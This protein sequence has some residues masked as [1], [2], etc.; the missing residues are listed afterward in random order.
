[1]RRDNPG[2][3]FLFVIDGAGDLPTVL[4]PAEFENAYKIA[5]RFAG[6]LGSVI[7]AAG[8]PPT[9]TAGKL[10]AADRTA[11]TADLRAVSYTHLAAG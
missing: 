9:G 7:P 5:V 6:D 11:N 8:R 10:L 4:T 1:M 2:H 3:R